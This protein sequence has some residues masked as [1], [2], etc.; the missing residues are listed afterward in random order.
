MLLTIIIFFVLLSI[1]VLVHEFG[2]F[3]TARKFGVG[4][5]EFGLG[6]PP[7]VFGWYRS[8]DGKGKW[9]WGNKEVTDAAKTIYSF[10]LVPIGGFVKIKGENGDEPN[11][12]DSFASRSLGK[13][14]LILSAGVIM[15]IIL[16]AV[17][18][19]IG[20]MAGLP[21]AVDDNALPAGVR[22]EN[23][24]IQIMQVLPK[25]PAE[26]AGLQ[27]GDVIKTI[28]GRSF[29]K[30]SQIQEYVGDK[31][32]KELSYSLVRGN[33]QLDK[34]ITPQILSETNNR[35]GIG[36]SIAETG[37]VKYP[38]YKAITEGFRLTALLLWAIIVG[39]VTIIGQ[40]FTGQSVSGDVVGPVG[41]AALTGQMAEMGFAYLAQFAALL[42]LHLA[43]IN[44]I[45]FPALDGGRVLFLIIEKIKGSP[46]K[47]KTEAIIHNLGFIILI[48]LIILVTFK[49][50]VKLF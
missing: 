3:I 9:V 27:P 45:P 39:L 31:A 49:D 12:P 25:T 24:Q 18:I 34:K 35:A 40:L 15:N 36:I 19:I 11:A 5:E 41:I 8:R 21:Q 17:I 32:G 22:V 26:A 37:I 29:E 14:A 44:F 1:L 10:N 2:H 33:E 4:A 28:D 30:Y 50:I 38:W 23:R 46:V 6:F 16:A 47:Q 20:L 43:I 48:G 13:R 7:R 42:S